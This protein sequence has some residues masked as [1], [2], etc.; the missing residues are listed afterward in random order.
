MVF[1]LINIDKVLCL[2]CGIG[3]TPFL[4]KDMVMMF[5]DKMFNVFR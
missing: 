2:Y 1:Y 4:E 5:T 3:G